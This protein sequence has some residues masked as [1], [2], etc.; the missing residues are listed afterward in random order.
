MKE[1]ETVEQYYKKESMLLNKPN[2][3]QKRKKVFEK[4]FC[5]KSF[6]IKF[7]SCNLNKWRKI[8]LTLERHVDRQK[9]ETKWQKIVNAFKQTKQ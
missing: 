1:M 8:S 5:K 7:H 3:R 6:G 9:M 4:L 2:N